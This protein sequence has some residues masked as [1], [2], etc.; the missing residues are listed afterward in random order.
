M[1]ERIS[2]A[3]ALLQAF[4]T[5]TEKYKKKTADNTMVNISDTMV[6]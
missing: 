5:N 2:M 3:Y 1:D 6:G 4:S